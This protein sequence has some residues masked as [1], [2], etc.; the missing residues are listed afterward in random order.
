MIH[1]Y[2]LGKDHLKMLKNSQMNDHGLIPNYIT[3]C[4]PSN[5]CECLPTFKTEL[6]L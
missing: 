3:E 6:I 2:E 5:V 4:L 1:I